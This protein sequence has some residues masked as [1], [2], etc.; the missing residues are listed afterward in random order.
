MIGQQY[1]LKDLINKYY[2][3]MEQMMLDLSSKCIGGEQITIN[4]P[5]GSITIKLK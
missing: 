3:P 4:F 1:Y 5:S 2:D